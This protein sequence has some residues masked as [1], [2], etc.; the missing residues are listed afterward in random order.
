M[1]KRY[2]IIS[3]SVLF[4]IGFLFVH[5]ELDLF[6]PDQHA[7]SAHDFCDIVDSAKPDNPSVEKFK[8]NNIEIQITTLQVPVILS[9]DIYTTQLYNPNKPSTDVDINILHSTFLI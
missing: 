3:L 4:V 2:H 8:V 7:H 1:K 6:T 5:S 9:K